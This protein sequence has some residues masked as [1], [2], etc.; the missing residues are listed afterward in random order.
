MTVTVLSFWVQSFNPTR[1]D[2]DIHAP[3]QSWPWTQKHGP[4]GP[5]TQAQQ[6]NDVCEWSQGVQE[7]EFDIGEEGAP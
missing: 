4:D 3:I 7:L 1:V 6:E 5:T 2:G